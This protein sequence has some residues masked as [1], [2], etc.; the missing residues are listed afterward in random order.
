MTVRVDR[1][2]GPAF[3]A[4]LHAWLGTRSRPSEGWLVP[5]RYDQGDHSRVLLDT[6]AAA[7][8]AAAQANAARLAAQ[9]SE[10]DAETTVDR[11]TKLIEQR[12]RGELTAA[13]YEAGRQKLLGQ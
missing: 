8:Q 13:E 2:D 7:R 5:V 4:T 12:D 3:D 10:A 11:L 9:T 1:P 6:S